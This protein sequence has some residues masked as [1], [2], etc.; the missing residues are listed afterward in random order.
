MN[1][2]HDA[3]VLRPDDENLWS[4]YADWLEERGDPRAEL[5]RRGGDDAPLIQQHWERWFPGI[6]PTSLHLKWQHGFVREAQLVD[7]RLS[8]DALLALPSMK[9]VRA[10]T[11][12]QP[13]TLGALDTLPLLSSLTIHDAVALKHVQLPTLRALDVP[14]SL[15]PYVGASP[16]LHVRVE[17]DVLEPDLERMKRT[18]P[19]ARFTP[20][21]HAQTNDF[22]WSFGPLASTTPRLAPKNV[23]ELPPWTETR[24]RGTQSDDDVITGVGS[25]AA[26]LNS[27]RGWLQRCMHCASSVV[28]YVFHESW[29]LYS[30]FETTTYERREFRCLVCSHF[31]AYHSVYER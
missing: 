19:H 14:S 18:F 5:M 20:Q 10:L 12:N 7:A 15:L 4:T 17:D 26:S 13:T 27:G 24:R 2:F 31:T 22:H 9:W 16:T 3:L 25:G 30:H 11:F 28:L 6:A 29:S 8:I 1:P 23:L 21:V